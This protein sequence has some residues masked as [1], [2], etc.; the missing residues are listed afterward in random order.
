MKTEKTLEN[1]AKFFALY[2]GQKIH[3]YRISKLSGKK[4]ENVDG[5]T[6]GRLQLKNLQ[7]ISDEDAIEVAKIVSEKCNEL[8][9]IV[10]TNEQV[11]LNTNGFKM[12]HIFFDGMIMYKD[13]D[14]VDCYT[15]KAFN[16]LDL[17]RCKGYLLPYLDLSIEQIIEYGWAKI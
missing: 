16:A 7:N 1:K 9:K 6:F 10:R 17:L 12:V 3:H 5:R 13:L 2:W 8:P 4:V 11:L 14:G 15:L